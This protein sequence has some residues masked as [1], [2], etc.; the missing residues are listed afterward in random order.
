MGHYQLKCLDRVLS[1][2]WR[3][4]PDAGETPEIKLST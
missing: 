1:C 4:A 3:T 2:G